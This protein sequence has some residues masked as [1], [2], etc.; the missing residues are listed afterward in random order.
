MKHITQN[1]LEYFFETALGDDLALSSL[2]LTQIQPIGFEYGFFVEQLGRN[3]FR[4]RQIFDEKIL[5]NCKKA[6]WAAPYKGKQPIIKPSEP[7]QV[8]DSFDD[9]FK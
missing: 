2:K 4:I 8:I 1:N 3:E 7:D 5:K 6:K 9:A